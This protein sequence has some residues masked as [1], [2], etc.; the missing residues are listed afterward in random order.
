MILLYM[1]RAKRAID[2]IELLSELIKINKNDI[3]VYEASKASR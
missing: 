1:R 3:I 2:I